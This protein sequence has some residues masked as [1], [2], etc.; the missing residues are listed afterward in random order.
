MEGHIYHELWI[1]HLK[2]CQIINMLS[3]AIS[4]PTGE[5]LNSAHGEIISFR[6]PSREIISNPDSPLS[7]PEAS[8]PEPIRK[9]SES[10]I[11]SK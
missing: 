10:P 6:S 8:S 11:Y 7:F 4:I 3:R 9:I 2:Y 5:C 1:N